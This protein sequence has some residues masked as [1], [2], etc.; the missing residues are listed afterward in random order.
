MRTMG[1]HFV[2]SLYVQLEYFYWNISVLLLGWS[3]RE[4]W[5]PCWQWTWLE[6]GKVGWDAGPKTGER[7]GLPL[8]SGAYPWILWGS[9]CR[10][11]SYRCFTC[12]LLSGLEL[13][14]ILEIIHV[15]NSSYSPVWNWKLLCSSFLSTN[16]K[17]LNTVCDFVMNSFLTF[18]TVLKMA[19]F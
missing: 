16:I 19:P 4:F 2:V 15:Y 12:R 5:G 11:Y 9:Q 7:D 14:L 3:W 18:M 8:W 6:G 1:L 10:I 17:V 13:F